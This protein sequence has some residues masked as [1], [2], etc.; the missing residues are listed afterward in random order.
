M[1]YVLYMHMLTYNDRQFY[2]QL[3]LLCWLELSI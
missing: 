1:Y 3:W 2:H